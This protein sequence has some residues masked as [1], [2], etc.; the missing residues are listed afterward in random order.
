MISPPSSPL[1]LT[2]QGGDRGRSRT[3]ESIPAGPP[4]S[5]RGDISQLLA[6]YER[7]VGRLG[8][9]G[10]IK[11]S[12]PGTVPA[13][14]TIFRGEDAPVL[15][16]SDLAFALASQNIVTVKHRLCKVHDLVSIKEASERTFFII[17]APIYVHSGKEGRC[18][19]WVGSECAVGPVDPMLCR[20][21]TSLRGSLLPGSWI[22]RCS[23]VY[24]PHSPLVLQPCV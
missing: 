16:G 24:C 17:P 3:R 1:T 19:P 6:D 9:V 11:P 23:F 10:E 15:T 22:A 13:S 20:S 8:S 4:P 2:P 14:G 5:V 7:S 21:T 18:C 12:A